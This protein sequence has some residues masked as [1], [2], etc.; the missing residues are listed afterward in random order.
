MFT[1]STGNKANHHI[2]CRS[3]K[4]NA[5]Q[6]TCLYKKE[7]G[8]LFSS[9]NSMYHISEHLCCYFSIQLVW[10]TTSSK[11][12]WDRWTQDRSNPNILKYRHV[13][14]AQGIRQKPSLTE[15]RCCGNFFRLEL[16]F[17]II[18]GTRQWKP[19]GSKWDTTLSPSMVAR[20]PSRW[21]LPG[22]KAG[23]SNLLIDQTKLHLLY[24]H[25]GMFIVEVI[26]YRGGGGWYWLIQGETRWERH[27]WWRR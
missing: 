11:S 15:W 24:L 26:A 10:T 9:P 3:F 25:L 2:S 6:I 27:T 13:H 14:K 7:S 4:K 17:L 21:R 19:F 16:E 12:S 18:V 8:L 1:C 20:S 22:R 23:I 5:T